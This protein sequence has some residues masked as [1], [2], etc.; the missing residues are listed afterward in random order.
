MVRPLLKFSGVFCRRFILAELLEA[1]FSDLFFISNPEHAGEFF[2]K[3]I[4]VFKEIFNVYISG[5]LKIFFNFW[6]NLIFGF[7]PEKGYNK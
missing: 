1:L 3:N 2:F 6:L 4:P 5:I 7:A